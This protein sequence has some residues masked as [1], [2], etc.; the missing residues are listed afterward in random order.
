MRLLSR[1]DGSW[2]WAPH[3][4]RLVARVAAGVTLA[5]VGPMSGYL[6]ALVAGAWHETR[7]RRPTPPITCSP[8]F[9]VVVP[10]HDE[11]ATIERLL[12]SLRAQDYPTDAYAVHVVADNCED[13]TAARARAM[14]VWVHERHDLSLRGKGHALAWVI[15]RVRAGDPPPDAWL[16]LD[17]DSIVAPDLLG[18]LA[19]TFARGAD[20]VQARYEALPRPD[21]WTSEA[22]RAAF[23]LINHVRPLGKR[24]FGGSAGLKGNGMA[25]TDDALRTVPW[26]ASSLAE[27]VE[28]HLRLIARGYRVTYAPEA[29]VWA[30]MP[31]TL[32]AAR[33]QNERWEAGRLALARQRGW[34]MLAYGIRHGNIT[35]LDAIIEQFVPPFAA[36]IGLTLTGLLAA[37]LGRSRRLAGLLGLSLLGQA[38][39]TFVGLKVAGVPRSTWLALARAPIYLLWKIGLYGRVVRG[40]GPREWVRTRR[41]SEP[42]RPG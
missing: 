9:A 35:A 37:V 27:D 13:D 1:G 25:F 32:A 29:R 19:A 31:T 15:P 7:R 26:R 23:T 21:S 42:P 20:V 36:L 34:A 38:C 3:G 4:A 8:T 16:F 10:A 30:D 41:A 40:R 24:W 33:S 11:A 2:A 14:G 6:V 18:Q 5:V 28:Q 12:M 39:Y 17:A 22:R